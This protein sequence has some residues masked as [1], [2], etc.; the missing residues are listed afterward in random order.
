MKRRNVDVSKLRRPIV[1]RGRMSEDIYGRWVK[2]LARFYS[3][4]GVPCRWCWQSENTPFLLVNDYV[5]R[6]LH[7]NPV[8]MIFDAFLKLIFYGTCIIGTLLRLG[9]IK[10]INRPTINIF[11]WDGWRQSNGSLLPVSN[12][13]S[14][15]LNTKDE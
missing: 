9:E 5:L 10:D 1:R 6:D 3:C 4:L 14:I 12:M 15:E 7:L 13:S 2:A 11:G 8:L